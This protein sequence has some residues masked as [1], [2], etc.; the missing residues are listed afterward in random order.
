MIEDEAMEMAGELTGVVGVE[1]EEKL[2]SSISDGDAL[3]EL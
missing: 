3:K 2:R 1:E